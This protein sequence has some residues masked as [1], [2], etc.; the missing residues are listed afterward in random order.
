[1]KQFVFNLLF[2]FGFVSHAQY[3]P[4]AI[5]YTPAEDC[6]LAMRI[7]NA[8]QE[9]NFELTG[10]GDIDDAHGSLDLIYLVQTNFT[11]FESRIC[12]IKFTPQYAGDLALIICPEN[13]ERL[14][15][16]IFKNY[17]CATLENGT[18]SQNT[19]VAS[20]NIT[21]WASDMGCMGLGQENNPYNPGANTPNFRTYLEP[22][23]V[24]AEYLLVIQTRFITQTGSHKVTLK[25]TGPVVTAHPDVFNHPSCVMSVESFTTINAT[26]Y[27]NP[28]NNSLQI[29]SNTT[30]KSMALYDVLGKQILNLPFNK[31]LNTT[32]LAQGVYLLHLI[33]EEGEVLVKKVVKE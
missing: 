24:G 28:F 5:F 9:Y 14:Q 15:F 23:E 7:C 25:F 31:T 33:T 11:Q 18:Y 32:N 8:T 12:F 13:L 10:D 4:A 30:F 29:E 17:N 1:M 6:P 21:T 27:P 3:N 16:Q 20:S 19:F 26:V 2:L 22:L